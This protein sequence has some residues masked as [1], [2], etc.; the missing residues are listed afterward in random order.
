MLVVSA[1]HP[2]QTSGLGTRSG[3]NFICVVDVVG[4]L[5]GLLV[6]L[7]R[8]FAALRKD[9]GERDEVAGLLLLHVLVGVPCGQVL[10]EEDRVGPLHALSAD[11]LGHVVGSLVGGGYVVEGDRVVGDVLAGVVEV[12][13]EVRQAALVG[14]AV[15]EAD[16]CCV[17][18]QDWRRRC[19]G[20]PQKVPQ[21]PQVL[22]LLDAVGQ[23]QVLRLGRSGGD[24][25]LLR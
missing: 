2:P 10:S 1:D 13:V 21:V 8:S 5:A 19:L 22:R 16:A 20:V 18:L 25:A 14:V 4:R 3:A 11:R 6:V 24:Q 23:Y 15:A 12:Y 17:V 9:R 7:A